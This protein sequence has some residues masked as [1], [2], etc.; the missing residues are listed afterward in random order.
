MGSKPNIY[1][2]KSFY[3]AKKK[4]SEIIDD[5]F[6]SGWSCVGDVRLV[7]DSDICWLAVGRNMGVCGR[8]Y[9]RKKK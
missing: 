5:Y 3:E 1:P 2:C 9:I 8:I 7:R 4:L 6:N